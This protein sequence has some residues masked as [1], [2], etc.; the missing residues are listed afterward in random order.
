MNGE[1]KLRIV[2]KGLETNKLIITA[3]PQL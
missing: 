2:F 1:T 3:Y